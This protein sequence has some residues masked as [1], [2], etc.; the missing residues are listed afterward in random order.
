MTTIDSTVVDELITL[1]P[2]CRVC[3][4]PSFTVREQSNPKWGFELDGHTPRKNLLDWLE[5]DPDRSP[6]AMAGVC[7][8]H[9]DVPRRPDGTYPETGPASSSGNWMVR[10]GNERRQARLDLIEALGGACQRCGGKSLPDQMRVI[11]PERSRRQFGIR[12]QTQWWEL[13]R[14]TPRLREDAKLLCV[15]CSPTAVSVNQTRQSARERVIKGYGGRCMFPDCEK[16]EGLLVVS[17][18]NTPT[19]RWPNGDKY[20][21]HSKMQYLLRHG[22]PDGWMVSC[23]AHQY[24]LQRPTDK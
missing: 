18:P 8:D 4:A 19:L 14:T 12:S 1:H 20:N 22:F 24:A 3:G 5:T 23:G 11:V 10:Q 16:T 7:L 2:N 13:V 6:D 9:L 17:G 15:G 21:S